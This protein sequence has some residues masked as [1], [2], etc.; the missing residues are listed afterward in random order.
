MREESFEAVVGIMA[1]K[2]QTEAISLINDSKYGLTASL[3]TSDIIRAEKIANQIETG[4]VF[5][6]RADYLD[7]ALCW[8]GFKNTGRGEALSVIGHHNLTRPKSYHFKILQIVCDRR[9][10]KFHFFYLCIPNQDMASN[11]RQTSPDID[12]FFLIV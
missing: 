2:S 4:T 11:S 10:K 9:S 8:T 5:L 7:P 1:V 6:N 3:W 12:A